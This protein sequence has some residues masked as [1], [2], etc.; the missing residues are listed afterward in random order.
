VDYDA[1]KIAEA[2]R[3]QIAHG[4]YERDDLFGDGNAARKIASILAEARPS[5]QKQLHYESAELQPAADL[6]P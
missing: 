5:V 1:G 4:P 2:M 6:S 3:A